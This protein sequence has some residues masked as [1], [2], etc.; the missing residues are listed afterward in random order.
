MR[1]VSRLSWFITLLLL[2]VAVPTAFGQTFRGGIAGTVTDASGAVIAGAKLTLV[3]PETGFSRL[4]ESTGA[5]EYASL[6][7]CFAGLIERGASQVDL[8]PLRLT[9]EAFLLGRRTAV[10]PF[11]E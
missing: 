6:Y 5:G 10:E 2:A 7:D 11:E 9:A 3:N 4:S 1:V 8:A